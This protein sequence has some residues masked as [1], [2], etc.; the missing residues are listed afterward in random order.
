M[1]YFLI[2]AYCVRLAVINAAGLERNG[3]FSLPLLR[4]V[5]LWLKRTSTKSLQLELVT[6]YDTNDAQ[7]ES[8]VGGG[9][10]KSAKGGP[11]PLADLD[12]GEG[13]NPL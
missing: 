11:Y 4:N 8:L 9:G 2:L 12:G 6:E 3:C 1:Q 13:P 5:V 10:S 7:K